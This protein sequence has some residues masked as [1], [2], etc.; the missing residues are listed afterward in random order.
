MSDSTVKVFGLQEPIRNES[1][2]VGKK[3]ATESAK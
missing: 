2:V 3:Y 1:H